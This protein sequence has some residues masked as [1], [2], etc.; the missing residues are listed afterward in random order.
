MSRFVV[1]ARKYR[2]DHF[3]TVLGQKQVTE[4]LKNAIKT[5]QLAQSFLFCGPRGVGKTSCARILAKTINCTNIGADFEACGTCD[6][7][8]S[9]ANGNSFNIQELDAASNNSVEDIRSLVEQIRYAP[10]AGKYKIYIIDEVHMLSQNAFNAFLKTLEEPPSYV[11][12]ILATTEKQKIIPTILSR[13]QIFDFNRITVQDAADHLAFIAGNEG[14]QFEPEALHLIAQKSDGAMRDA[15]SIFDQLSIFTSGN[16]SYKSVLENLHILDQDYYFQITEKV[17]EEDIPGVLLIFDE[18][19]KNGFNGNDFLS[20]LSTYYRDLLVS[21][22]ESTLKL[23]EV[24]PQTQEKY[25]LHASRISP[26]FLINALS[27]TNQAEIQYRNSRNQRL[28][29]EL[30]L[31][32]LCHIPSVFR[33]QEGSESSALKKKALTLDNPTDTQVHLVKKEAESVETPLPKTS[34]GIDT[35][36]SLPQIH[37]EVKQKEEKESPNLKPSINKSV[38]SPEIRFKIPKKE[39]FFKPLNPENTETPSI[40][41]VKKRNEHFGP[42]QVLL[43]WKKLIKDVESKQNHGLYSILTPIQPEWCP[44]SLIRLKVQNQVQKTLILEEADFIIQ[45]LREELKNDFVHFEYQ[46]E[47][48]ETASLA[49]FTA[50]DKLK[51]LSEINPVL[52]KLKSQLGF[53]IDY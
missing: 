44:E 22:D 7:C 47:A 31:I 25:R 21:K 5:G 32:K 18:I 40:P 19:L 8:I 15:L 10:Q 29:V 53:D 24:M 9:F 16:I 4:T 43:A 52:L 49:P 45:F 11:I 28:Q 51:H 48:Y 46:I 50:E 14:I 26:A 1:S 39:E 2:P 42:E 30:A 35:P 6:S 36:V 33:F 17:L 23:L 34:E 37:L 12:F 20:G 27:I 41:I 38:S 3:N 13:C